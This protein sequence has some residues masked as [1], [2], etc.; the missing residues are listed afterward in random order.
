MG[1]P[2]VAQARI[3]AVKSLRHSLISLAMH[4]KETGRSDKLDAIRLLLEDLPENS[5]EEVIRKHLPEI[6]TKKVDI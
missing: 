1:I 6:I 3:D 4:F 5:Y 2:N